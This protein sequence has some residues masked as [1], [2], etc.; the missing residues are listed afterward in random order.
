MF[1]FENLDVY[2][3]AIQFPAQASTMVGTLPSGH[4]ALADQ[5]KR[6]SLSVPLD[7]AEGSGRTGQSDLRRHHAIARGSAIECAAILDACRVLGLGRGDRI[8]EARTL[9]E[10][11]V[12]MLSKMCR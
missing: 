12:S 3:C 5:L 1:S 11:I 6:A 2:K 7:I 8:E 9:L 10:R 4:A